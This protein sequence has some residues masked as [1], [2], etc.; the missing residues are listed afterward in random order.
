MSTGYQIYD[1]AGSYYLTFQVVDWIDIFTRK[2]YRGIILG[3][4]WRKFA[5]CANTIHKRYMR[6]GFKLKIYKICDP[7]NKLWPSLVRKFN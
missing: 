1:K 6:I 5:T 3:L 4:C 7:R 2:V